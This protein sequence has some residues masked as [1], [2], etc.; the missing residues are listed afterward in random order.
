M[1]VRLSRLPVNW[2]EQPQLF[3]RY[4]DETLS[5]IEKTLNAILA[6][7]LIQQAVL[8]AQAAADAAQAAANSAQ[9]AADAAQGSAD[10]QA[11]ETSLVN[12]YTTGF[13][14]ALLTANTSGSVTIQAHTRVYGDSILNPNA[15]VSGTV[16][17]TGATP[18]QI[19][20]VFYNDPVRTG[21]AVSYYFT[22]DPAV[23][24]AQSGN[25]HSVG[26]VEIPA[27]GTNSGKNL[28]PPGYIEL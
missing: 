17:T 5:Q 19:V 16:L 22:I 7:P 24:P 1:S 13:A 10:A 4:W 9:T 3:E 11:R 8:D 2:R 21:G 26:A 6:I 18:G 12:S 20:R 28:R 23:F 25:T 27:V 14:G 15:S